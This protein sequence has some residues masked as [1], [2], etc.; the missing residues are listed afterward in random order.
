ML[1]TEDFVA[2]ATLVPE[3]GR[4]FEFDSRRLNE[5]VEDDAPLVPTVRPLLFSD[6]LA[7]FGLRV[8]TVGLTFGLRPIAVLNSSAP[9]LPRETRGG[10]APDIPGTRLL[11]MLFCKLFCKLFCAF[12]ITGLLVGRSITAFNG[13]AAFL[14]RADSD[15]AL[16]DR[17]GLVRR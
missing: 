1:F 13:L 15:I 17:T 4:D 5:L 14:L 16:S 10:G 12:N 3:P 8:F 11:C 9:I 7:K 6:K 2:L